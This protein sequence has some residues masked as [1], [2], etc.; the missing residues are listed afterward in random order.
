MVQDN[1]KVL[2]VQYISH[3]E[4]DYPTFMALDLLIRWSAIACSPLQFCKL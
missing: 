2:S 1:V 3:Y 4:I